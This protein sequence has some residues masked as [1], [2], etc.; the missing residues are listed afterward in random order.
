[1]IFFEGNIVYF[2]ARMEFISRVKVNVKS[3]N[4]I[5]L[6]LLHGRLAGSFVTVSSSDV[7]LYIAYV[8]TFFLLS[9]HLL[10]LLFIL[11]Y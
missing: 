2:P 11:L 5:A 10:N 8:R 1:M 7:C 6:I 9:L 3:G 4:V